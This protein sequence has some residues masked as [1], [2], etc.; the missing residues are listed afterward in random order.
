[1]PHINSSRTQART[2]D[3]PLAVAVWAYC[4]PASASRPAADRRKAH[5]RVRTPPPRP[6]RLTAH[7]RRAPPDPAARFKAL[8]E[9]MQKNGVTLPSRTPGARRPPGTGRLFGWS[10][11]SAA[12]ERRDPRTVS[13]PPLKKCGG[14]AFPGGAGAR[15]KSPAYQAGAREVRDMHARKR[16]ERAR[17]PTPPATVRSSTPKD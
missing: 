4:S 6:R 3:G 15:L 10:G 7:G 11:R 9:C 17:R 2:S 16:R 14:G 1:M 5:P 12:A 8:R 13:K